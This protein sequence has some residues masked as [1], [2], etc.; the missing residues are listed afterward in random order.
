MSKIDDLS[1][2]IGDIPIQTMTKAVKAKSRDFFWYSPVLKDRLDHV[3][4]DAVVSPR[5]QNEVLE[6]LAACYDLDIYVTARGAGTGNYGQSMPLA[7]GIVLD[8]SGF[9]QIKE[10]RDGIVVTEP[11]VLIG[12]LDEA[13]KSAT[14]QE[15]RMH[16]ST[17]ETATI[18][19]FISGGSAGV[20]SITWGGLAVPGNIA[21]IRIAT[22]EAAPRLIDLTGP[23]IMQ[24]HHAYGL[25]G[26]ITEVELPLAPAPDWVA[27]LV[28]FKNWK[29]CLDVGY[30]IGRTDGFWLKQLGAVQAPAPFDYFTRHRKFLEEGDNLLCIKVAPNSVAALVD[31]AM[32]AGGRIAF[33]ADT[34]T[35][36]EK[37][38]LPH[39]HH[40]MWNHTTLRA[41]KTDQAMTYLQ[42]SFPKDD[43]GACMEIAARFPG[44]IINHVEFSRGEGQVR[45]AGL[46]IVRFSTEARLNALITELEAMGCEIWN[47]HAYTWEEGNR[48]D[49][50][51]DLIAMKKAYDPKGLLNPGKLIGW[52]QP[53]YT[54][55][56]LGGYVYGGLQ[57]VPT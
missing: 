49:A 39:L 29:T 25:T 35:E 4:A 19:G 46:P 54:Y 5:T 7:G 45:M 18:G 11:G 42:M 31:M 27:V 34:A 20:G 9:N 32:R 43:I 55:E 6:V 36:E 15:L 3:V 10:I 48:S 30:S 21:R 1:A 8:L 22:M 28:A 56:P 12:D 50:N 41:L 53:T 51:P 37:K 14:G 13:C 40:L 52:E 17:R 2:R 23:D 33:R 16:P 47:P 24:A 44:E 38:G 57:K 26:I